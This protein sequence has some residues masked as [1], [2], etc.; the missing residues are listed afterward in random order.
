[1][2][3]SGGDVP[4]GATEAGSRPGPSE[5]VHPE[6]RGALADLLAQGQGATARLRLG[7]PTAG[8][9]PARFGVQPGTGP[10][11]QLLVA[12]ALAE[13]GPDGSNGPADPPTSAGAVR[14]EGEPV[15][16]RRPE[17]AAAIVAACPDLV[18]VVDGTG[19]L[20]Q[21]PTGTGPLAALVQGLSTLADLLERIHPEDRP[22]VRLVYSRLQT[23][24]AEEIE[25][26]YRLLERAG[27]WRVV[28]SRGRA[29]RDPEGR[30]RALVTLTRDVTEAVEAETRLRQATAE[31]EAAGEA[32][33]EL[34]SRLS[35]ELRTPLNAVLGFAQLLAL[36]DLEPEQ[37]A[38]V[39]AIGRA[40]AELARLVEDLLD[41]A[42]LETGRADLRPEALPVAEVL[43]PLQRG[44]ALTLRL[45][46]ALPPV[47][48]DRRRLV[49]VLH[50]LVV[51]L[52]GSEEV[53]VEVWATPSADGRVR[54]AVERAE[55]EDGARAGAVERR[56]V[57]PPA[58]AG[59]ARRSVE[60]VEDLPVAR[61]RDPSTRLALARY[62][63]QQMGGRL[64]IV[65]DPVVRYE[66]D[67]PAASPAGERPPT[68]RE[69]FAAP[70]GSASPTGTTGRPAAEVLVVGA[71][72]ALLAA[73]EA[74][75]THRPWVRVQRAGTERRLADL[76]AAHPSARLVLLDLAALYGSSSGQ[77]SAALGDL[78]REAPTPDPDRPGAPR[79]AALVGLGSDDAVGRRLVRAGVLD[80]FLRL[81]LDARAL[82][83]LLDG[84]WGDPV[85]SPPA[86]RPGT[87]QRS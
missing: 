72:P 25:V 71:D 60:R 74:V 19:R 77:V 55:A 47:R 80:A 20:L 48:A 15:R 52:G 44:L 56:P 21:P 3:A 38:R 73:L 35:H 86:P 29:E 68:R 18:T 51:A 27:R 83:E 50:T 5:L 85:T 82:L 13:P 54:L 53:P 6:D 65:G 42:R 2:L 1:M 61:L 66:L 64:A 9:R 43:E 10:D 81:P 41:L 11:E 28:E 62:L 31:A 63:L 22:L 67:L 23:G 12:V 14:G 33:S 4:P 46:P 30:L 69:P 49:Q 17:V 8:W 78:D 76:L 24:E 7:T 45:D 57:G 39:E 58:P 16:I 36:E 79:R 34:L 32:R 59:P 84:L 87:T 75:A 26:R 37:A 40:A 70:P